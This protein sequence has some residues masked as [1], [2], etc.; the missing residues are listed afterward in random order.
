M[1]EGK[2]S[3]GKLSIDENSFTMGVS[4]LQLI[5]IILLSYLFY[6]FMK[7]PNW[8]IYQIGTVFTTILLFAMAVLAIYFIYSLINNVFKL[9]GEDNIVVLSSALFIWLSFLYSAISG[10]TDA[11]MAGATIILV[12]VTGYNISQTRKYSQQ[13]ID[14]L[15]EQIEPNVVA[16]FIIE[17]NNTD[18]L[19]ISL[20]NIGKGIAKSVK[21]QF[22]P[23]NITGYNNN[24]HL[25]PESAEIRHFLPDMER[26]IANINISNYI[27]SQEH[28]P[29]IKVVLVI[30]DIHDKTV[31][32]SH[33]FSLIDISNLIKTT[34]YL[35]HFNEGH[36]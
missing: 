29:I 33:D 16:D 10:K 32:K 27:L 18:H 8:M 17:R 1:D 3:I 15:K 5:D 7:F 26:V 25:I 9:K 28:V 36:P 30:T 13:N 4:I 2:I 14:I 31:K 19:I 6:F 24:P 12:I 11:V 35:N 20:K 23:A 34:I 22:E 21:F